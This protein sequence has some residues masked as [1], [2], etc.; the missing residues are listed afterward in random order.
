MELQQ[1]Q[2]GMKSLNKVLQLKIEKIFISNITKKINEKFYKDLDEVLSSKNV[3]YFQLRLK[4]QS[5]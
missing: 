3:K 5:R 4:K 2:N 1:K